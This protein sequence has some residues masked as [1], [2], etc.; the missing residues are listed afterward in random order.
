VNS[1]ANNRDSEKIDTIEV[2]IDAASGDHELLTV[3]ETGRDTGQFSGF[4]QSTRSPPPGEQ[5]DCRL[6][7]EAE[8][9]SNFLAGPGSSHRHG[10]HRAA[11]A[12]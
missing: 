1:P 6:A 9:W 12:G 2:A 4:L 8:T 3:Y 10:A 7:V 5:R 11:R